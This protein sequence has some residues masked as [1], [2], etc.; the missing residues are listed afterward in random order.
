MPETIPQPPSDLTRA[1]QE[2]EQRLL[3]GPQLEVR[4]TF[5]SM[6]WAP[7]LSSCQRYPRG[8]HLQRWCDAAAAGRISKDELA[9]TVSLLVIVKA[10]QV[11]PDAAVR[12]A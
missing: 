10:S 6:C 2:A 12:A 7:P 4:R 3:T 1:R 11:I 8:D 5:C 9:A